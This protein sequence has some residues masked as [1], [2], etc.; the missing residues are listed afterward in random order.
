MVLDNHKVDLPTI[1]PELFMPKNINRA[2]GGVQI[3]SGETARRVGYL[4]NTKWTEP[5][6]EEEGFRSCSCDVAWRSANKF[7]T[8]AIDIPNL[9][10]IRHEV[11]GRD[12]D[13]GGNAS[14]TT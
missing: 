11:N 6:S 3:I 1:D 12:L 4:D 13:L 2:I 5:V 10:R 9:Y 7:P 8:V 14:G